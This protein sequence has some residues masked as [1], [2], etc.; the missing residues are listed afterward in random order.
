[1]RD[2]DRCCPVGLGKCRYGSSGLQRK[3]PKKRP[4]RASI[5]CV[6][7]LDCCDSASLTP[8]A[9]ESAYKNKQVCSSTC[10][11]AL[12]QPGLWQYAIL[13]GLKAG[14]NWY[15]RMHS[16]R[17]ALISCLTALLGGA[18]GDILAQQLDSVGAFDVARTVRLAAYCA[19]EGV[20]SYYW[21]QLLDKTVDN[22]DSPSTKSVATKTLVH[23]LFWV[24][25]TTITF[26]S[27]LKLLE[28]HPDQIPNT[29]NDKAWKVL[30]AKGVMEPMMSLINFQFVPTEM[31]VL[32]DN[33][34][35]VV[36]STYLSITS[37]QI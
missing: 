9:C 29:L 22:H 4:L 1:M 8:K 19:L 16:A 35:D 13:D 14:I 21:Y 17:P 10:V 27:C 6:L 3:S 31:R 36:S 30:A 2:L 26:L 12:Y 11:G 23:Q 34:S 32:F 5:V 25:I 28:G 33:V 15:S 24:P 18:V 20:L 7:A 37:R